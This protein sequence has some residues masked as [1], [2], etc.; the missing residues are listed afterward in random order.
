MTYQVCTACNQ[1]YEYEHD[2]PKCTC[3]KCKAA[4]PLVCD[5]KRGF[6]DFPFC[7]FGVPY[8]CHTCY[9]EQK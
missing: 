8:R 4:Y 9:M 2:C 6:F 1:E 5:C 3:G 7:S